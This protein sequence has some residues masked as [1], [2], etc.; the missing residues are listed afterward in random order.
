MKKLFTLFLALM[1]MVAVSAR[2][3]AKF[4]AGTLRTFDK[5][6]VVKHNR[7]APLKVAPLMT[8]TQTFNVDMAY[9]TDYGKMSDGTYDYYVTLCNSQTTYPAMQF[10]I[11]VTNP[12]DFSGKYSVNAGNLDVEYGYIMNSA[13]EY[14]Y[15]FMNDCEVT[16]TKV[17]N[18][19]K[20]EGSAVGYY[21][22]DTY[23]FSFQSAIDVTPAY[24]YDYEPDEVTT[25]N[26]VAGKCEIEDMTEDYGAA[27][28][29][30]TKDNYTLELEFNAAELNGGKIPAGTYNIDDSGNEGT[31]SM[32]VGGDDDYDYGCYLMVIDGE[33]Y[34]PY[35]L[36]SGTVTVSY[37]ESG[38]MSIVVDAKSSKNSTIQVTYEEK[39]KPTPQPG[40]GIV[41]VMEDYQSASFTSDEGIEITTEGGNNPAV[42]N[43]NSK[44]LRV[45]AT[46]NL[47]IEAG[48]LTITQIV[49]DLSAQGLKRQAEI[50]PSS[51]TMTYDIENAQVIW[52]GS[53]TSVT[54]TVG[55]KAKYGSESTKAGQFDFTKITITTSG[56]TPTPPTPPTPVG[57]WELYEGGTCTY[58]YTAIFDEPWAQEGLPIYAMKDASNANITHF[59]IANWMSDDEFEG[60]DLYVDYNSATGLCH[61]PEQ[62]IGYE[63]PEYGKVYVADLSNYKYCEYSYDDYPCEFNEATGEF[64]LVL[65]YFDKSTNS[66]EDIWGVAYEYIDVDIEG[67]GPGPTPSGDNLIA[68]GSFENW[69]NDVQPTG[70]EGWQ[71]SEFANTSSA[72]LEKTTDAYEGNYACI[73]KGSTSN[74][75]LATSALTLPAGTYTV[76]FFAKAVSGIAA[77]KPGYA[78]M[79]SNGSAEYNYGE[80]AN[81]AVELTGNW[82]EIMYEFTLNKTTELSMVVMNYKNPGADFIIDAYEL[83]AGDISGINDIVAE[84]ATNGVMYNLA[85]QK[86]GNGYKGI[87]IINGKKV[88]LK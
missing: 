60:V 7:K 3:G 21:T 82:K 33:Y 86:V 69:N 59:K 36:V 68:N 34:D 19:Y 15:D 75:R 5:T 6:K 24:T 48:G 43:S 79:Q 18:E 26:F 84:T 29:T 38:L 49:F 61:V 35:Y 50:T 27:Y 45:Y 2:E 42:Y 46:G 71:I 78:T 52:T 47:T 64:T 28:V 25:I 23:K 58:T 53:A 54:F 32:S 77:V 1:T 8:A 85:G 81:E 17:G 74:V 76:R 41:I 83:K 11:Y 80:F 4:P 73:V 12:D 72:N 57:E 20:V 16:F 67:P 10:D 87:A 14:D 51:G 9:I 30:L 56:D 40:E 63:D 70:W 66:S 22:E 31:F 55:D 37:N 65:V 44:D 13:D 62:Y 88:L 39:E